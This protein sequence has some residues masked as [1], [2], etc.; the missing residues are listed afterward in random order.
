MRTVTKVRDLPNGATGAVQALYKVEP[1]YTV[2]NWNDE[3]TCD[4]SYIVVSAVNAMFSGPETYIFPAR[5]DGEIIDWGELPGSY[6]GDYDHDEAI[7][8]FILATADA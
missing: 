4:A 6:R 8:G 1:P 5:E 7:Q 3:P 2:R